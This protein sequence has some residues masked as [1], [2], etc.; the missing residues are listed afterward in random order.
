LETERR[1]SHSGARILS[2]LKP[3]VLA[4]TLGLPSDSTILKPRVSIGFRD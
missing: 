4:H 2:H 1:P 3:R